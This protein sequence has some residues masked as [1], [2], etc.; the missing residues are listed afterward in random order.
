MS[1]VVTI[2]NK[3]DKRATPPIFR[4]FSFYKDFKWRILAILLVGIVGIVLFSV[5]PIFFRSVF[6]SLGYTIMAGVSPQ[7]QFIYVQLAI[8]GVFI[9]INELFTVFCMF[10]LLQYERVI[11][12]E[13]LIE[14]KGKLDKV[15]IS[16]FEKYSTGDLTRR[17]GDL[18][19]GIINTTLVVVFRISR[20]IFFCI[21]TIIIMMSI[22]WILALVVISSLPLS[23]LVAK[24]VSKRT[25]KFFNTHNK[26]ASNAFKYVEQTTSLHG[27]YRMHGLSGTEDEY[28]EVNNRHAKAMVGENVSISFN[29][30]YI[31]FI[32]NFMSLLVTVVFG[33]LFVNRVVP[34]FGALPAFLI[35][36]NRFL[37]QAVIVTESTNLLQ[38]VNARAAY[39]FD[40]LDQPEMS[41]GDEHIEIESIKDIQFKNVSYEANGEKI[42]R[43]INLTIPQGS[44]IAIVGPHGNGKGTMVELL[45]K[46]LQP[47]SGQI[48]I[49]GV[50]LSVIK[51]RSYYHR[52][53]IAFE[54]PFI[55]RGTVAEN[56][57]YGVRRTLPEH[58]MG[59]TKKLGSHTFIEQLP[60]KYETMLSEDTSK[61][62]R[63]QK[64]AIN[65]ARTVL[66]SPDLVIFSDAMS[67]A[68]TM[69]EAET[70]QKIMNI[71]KKQ[72][73]IFITQHLSAIE[74][75]D[76]IVYVE[77]GRIVEM[78]THAELMK[79]KKKYFE[80]FM[81]N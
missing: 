26:V 40:I 10:V 25:Q 79:K 13:K 20:T 35:Y 11:K 9:L 16:F 41:R 28:N 71:D 74:K 66:Q 77:R 54:K 64:Q 62:T 3:R 67:Y 18:V 81:S 30:I 38:A 45:A 53:G 58:V 65:M 80:A 19:T 8:F 69:T 49:D 52:M 12:V 27:F 63:S 33:I 61:L 34:E 60:E 55:F 47:T 2:R 22:N 76:M 48:L 42:L 39:V 31:T 6:D 29:T 51:S 59:V 36:G 14:V 73:T 4:V 15:P 50:P 23:I 1:K 46:L 24:F 78:G 75:C 21:T 17:V 70:Y 57:L 43:K 56:L 68:D 7:M 5:T 37:A 32:Q 72:T 44:S